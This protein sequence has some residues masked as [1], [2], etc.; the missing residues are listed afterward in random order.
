MVNLKIHF[1]FAEIGLGFFFFY[2]EYCKA[3]LVVISWNMVLCWSNEALPCD[4]PFF[5]KLTVNQ[6]VQIWLAVTSPCKVRTVAWIVELTYMHAVIKCESLLG[7]IQG[8]LHCSQG[9]LKWKCSL[10]PDDV[11]DGIRNNEQ[12]AG[13]KKAMLDP[14]TVQVVFLLHDTL[15][16]KAPFL[17]L[18]MF[19]GSN[20]QKNW[21]E[22]R[23]AS[24]PNL[25]RTGMFLD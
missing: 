25:E 8:A 9:V 15:L 7:T 22:K 2:L 14:L 3:M 16:W 12:D 13:F 19:S 6:G 4:S 10:G 5:Y 11:R 23:S 20:R 24:S 17:M 1:T 18:K 21:D